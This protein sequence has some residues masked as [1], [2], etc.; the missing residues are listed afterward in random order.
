VYVRAP[1]YVCYFF[2]KLPFKLEFF[3]LQN[4]MQYTK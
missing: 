4:L 1:P 3:R 2:L